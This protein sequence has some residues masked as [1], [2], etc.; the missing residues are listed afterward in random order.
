ME[1]A[2]FISNGFIW[3]SSKTGSMPL[4]A[5]TNTIR[6]NKGTRNILTTNDGSLIHGN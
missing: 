5:A 6:V 3:S 1:L 2:R 4:S